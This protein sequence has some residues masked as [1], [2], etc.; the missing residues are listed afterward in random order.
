[1]VEGGKGASL[2]V[3]YRKGSMEHQGSISSDPAGRSSPC[4]PSSP[5]G[6]RVR[7]ED[8]PA[9]D[10]PLQHPDLAVADQIPMG[11]PQG[12]PE[13]YAALP[14]PLPQ[15]R[16]LERHHPPDPASIPFTVQYMQRLVSFEE[17]AVYF[18]K[19]EWDLLDPGQR[20][21]YKEVMLENYGHVASG[22]E[23]PQACM[24]HE[25]NFSDRE[26]PIKHQ[27]TYTGEKPYK[28]R[29]CGKSISRK[30]NLTGSLCSHPALLLP[31]LVA[32]GRSQKR[33]QPKTARSS[34]LI[35][36]RPTRSRWEARK[37]GPEHHAALPAPL[38]Q[39]RVSR[40]TLPTL[41]PLERH[42]P[43]DPASLPFTVQYMRVMHIIHYI[44]VT[45][46]I[47]RKL[48][49]TPPSLT[50]EARSVS[51]PL[52]GRV[53]RD[54]PR[55]PSTRLVSFEEVAVYF[56]KEEW[57]L[58]DPGQRALYKE[59]MLENY[60]HVASVDLPKPDVISWL[61][62][63]E[64][65]F[66][67]VTEEGE[68]L[69]GGDEQD[70][71]NYWKLSVGSSERTKHEAGDELFGNQRSA[72][73]HERNQ[74]QKWR[75]ESSDTHCKTHTG[76]KPQ[77]CM[78]HEKN[79]SDKE[80]P[81]KHQATYTEEKPYK[82]R[83]C[84]KSISR[85]DNLTVHE[86]THT[87]EKPYKCMVCGKSFRQK[88]GLSLHERTHTGEKP[89]KCMECG[90]TFRWRSGLVLH[91][92]T[93]T[94]EKPYKCMEC[95]KS[96]SQRSGLLSHRRTH[97]GEKPYKCM[98]CEKSFGWHIGLVSHQRTH[99]GEKPYKCMVCGKSFNQKIQLTLHQRTHTGEKPY[100]CMECGNSFSEKR[101]LREH[102]RTC[103]GITSYRCM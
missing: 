15:Q 29:W 40:G 39:Q 8:T 37:G 48:T 88:V 82:C 60:G 16:P 27:A 95:G 11:S 36:P 22:G 99:T 49:H 33:R 54:S 89:Y 1:M 47:V 83:W 17:V 30:D 67:Q 56:T 43:P 75:K 31:D 74:S 13:H 72:K 21:L 103:A 44:V 35:S 73:W 79:F 100:K 53:E 86:R 96:F 52:C 57:D 55:R 87:G 5:G 66:I 26:L 77:A 70:S 85:K 2:G 69:A 59:V 4:P 3:G 64:D 24:E 98:E 84:G 50:S 61:E 93:H 71:E 97:T 65:P 102:Q 38:P 80:L 101:R 58:L 25:K 14:T 68:R 42:H 62:K 32:G 46:I 41:E 81:I 45:P 76:E 9:E 6:G 28:C 18:T 91:R 34:I 90:K 10:C 92:R 7:R 20:A 23:K 94:G 51:S 19:E 78:E 63:G 12:G